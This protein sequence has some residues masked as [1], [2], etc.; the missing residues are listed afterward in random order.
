M[1]LSKE[2]DKELPRS[3]R[4][5]RESR[6]GFAFCFSSLI[7][8]EG[9]PEHRKLDLR[10]P[11]RA[12]LPQFASELKPGERNEVADEW[13]TAGSER[14]NQI[15]KQGYRDRLIP[16]NPSPACL[17]YHISTPGEQLF[18][19]AKEASRMTRVPLTI[20]LSRSHP[21]ARAPQRNLSG[22]VGI[23][24]Q[25]PVATWQRA[26]ADMRRPPDRPRQ[27]FTVHCG[28]S[29]LLTV[30]WARNPTFPEPRQ[31]RLP[32]PPTHGLCTRWQLTLIVKLGTGL[33]HR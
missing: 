11:T 3:G 33:V 6:L 20:R 4:I 19:F 29:P 22:F 14:T 16:L 8:Y 18:H 10:R 7:S 27:A 28:V 17:Q 9:L 5:K 25:L 30:A 13:K 2:R 32:C 21:P 15:D 12:E 23:R 1:D 24:K 31:L 26:L